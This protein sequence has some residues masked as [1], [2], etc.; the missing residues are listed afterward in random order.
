MYEGKLMNKKLGYLHFWITAVCSYGI[1]FPMHFVGLAGLPRRYYSN[2]EFPYFD[3]LADMNV[4]I[5]V[6]AIIAAAAQLIFLWNFFYSIFYGMK[7]SRNSGNALLKGGLHH[8]SIFTVTG[9]GHY[10]LFTVGH[11]TIVR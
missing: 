5:T 8:K 7:G 1:F 11:M 10:Q 9:M 4:M 3:D 2:T 6:F